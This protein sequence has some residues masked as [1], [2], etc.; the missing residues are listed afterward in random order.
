MNRISFSRYFEEEEQPGGDYWYFADRTEEQL[1]SDV[2]DGFDYYSIS[3]IIGKIKNKELKEKMKSNLKKLFLINKDIYYLIKNTFTQ[4]EIKELISK[5]IDEQVSSQTIDSN[6]TW[7]NIVDFLDVDFLVPMYEKILKSSEIWNSKETEDKIENFNMILRISNVKVRNILLDKYKEVVPKE[8]TKFLEISQDEYY[9]RKKAQRYIET[10]TENKIGI[11]PKIKIGAE[12]EA[13]NKLGI[14]FRSEN[15][16]GIGFYRSDDEPTVSEG[17]EV[18]TPIFHDTPEEIA[19]FRA[20][21]ET[22]EEQGYYYDEN[23]GN[24]S[25][26]VNIGIDYFNSALA[27]SIFY[28]LFCNSEEL[29][30]HIANKEGQLTRQQVYV[31]SKFKP[32]SERVAQRVIDENISFE[33]MVSY[34]T[35]PDDM[36]KR[37]KGESIESLKWK[38]DSICLRDRNRFEIRIFNGSTEFKV[39]KENILLMGK[40]AEIANRCADVILLKEEATKEDEEM[41]ELRE[42]LRDID[43]PLEEKLYVLMDLLFRERDDLKQIYIDRFYILEQKIEETKTTKYQDPPYR[44]EKAFGEVEFVKIYQSRIENSKGTIT[45]DPNEPSAKKGRY[46]VYDGDD[47]V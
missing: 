10:G 12:I 36:R 5:V 22:M 43:L 13:N 18:I 19:V 42:E 16:S 17:R 46:Q 33:D 32:V 40:M 29:L 25:G 24:A 37:K 34:L 9:V 44:M 15:Q 1:R 45:F 4:N 21:L 7:L 35:A 39:W 6:L 14:V 2:E 20:M 27:L 31:N 41:L 47:R 23:I 3:D 30:F 26:Q 38:K 8:G 11:D 28:E